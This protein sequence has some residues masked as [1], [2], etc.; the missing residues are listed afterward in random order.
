MEKYENERKALIKKQSDLASV[1]LKK[2]LKE[3]KAKN[4]SMADFY[5]RAMK[6]CNYRIKKLENQ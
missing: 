5:M 1:Y 4:S 2:H 3:K 6:M